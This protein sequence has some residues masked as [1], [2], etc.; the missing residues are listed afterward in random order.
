M[1][2]ILDVH[3][4]MEPRGKQRPRI[5]KNGH[6]FTPPQTINAEKQIRMYARL[7]Y[8]QPPVDGP[9]KLLVQAF[10]LKPKSAP[11][12]RLYPIVTPDWDNLGKLVSDALN[13][14]IYLDDKQIIS[15]TVEKHYCKQF[16][17]QGFRIVVKEGGV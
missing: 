13:K 17:R 7:Q 6:V 11:K 9:V 5:S 2:V 16:V 14:L 8:K 10:F 12:D 3:V 4:P 1:T 15:A